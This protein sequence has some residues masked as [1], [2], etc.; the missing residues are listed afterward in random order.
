MILALRL[1]VLWAATAAGLLGWSEFLFV[2]E[3]P[4]RAV[5]SP[6]WAMALVDLW[7][8]Y[9]I[10]A[11]ALMALWHLRW[12]ATWWQAVIG[13]ALVGWVIEGAVVAAVYEAPPFSFLWTSVAWHGPVDVA[14]GLW[15]LPRLLRRDVKGWFAPAWFV[16]AGALIGF[17]A[18]WTVGEE[19]EALNMTPLAFAWLAGIGTACAAAGAW[20]WASLGHEVT[21][22][23]RSLAWV[24]LGIC[25][26]L[27]A[28]Q[29][30]SAPFAFA[31]LSLLVAFTFWLYFRQR[32]R[33]PE[34]ADIASIRLV[35]FT[36]FAAAAALSYTVSLSVTLNID[37]EFITFIGFSTGLLIAAFALV[38]GF[39]SR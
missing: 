29:G 9:L 22:L 12:P 39:I 17:W 25:A 34:N 13:G 28:A 31:G 2:N 16:G 38:R 5:L 1:T 37:V 36:L 20:A 23:P 24:A 14:L 4:A 6:G 32:N 27:L 33:E 21:R 7:A 15:L 3:G 10:P 8:F 26:T 30:L 35:W 19:A 18:L 11:A